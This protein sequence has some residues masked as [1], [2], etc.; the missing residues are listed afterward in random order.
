MWWLEHRRVRLRATSARTTQ[1]RTKRSAAA[2]RKTLQ[3]EVLEDRR[4]LASI[5]YDS[6]TQQVVMS[7]DDTDDYAY[8]LP[9]GDGQ[10]V[11]RIETTDDE[12]V[13][14]IYT[15][16]QV[17]EVVFMGKEGNDEF[18]NR[19]SIRSLAFGG[20]GDDGLN[21]GSGDDELDGGP[22]ADRLSGNLGNDVL[23]G[24]DGH[25]RI[26]GGDGDD[27]LQG[28][29]GDDRLY[30]DDGQDQLSGGD[31]EDRLYGDAG[32]DLI[33]GGDATD[34]MYGGGG[35]DVMYGNA[36]DDR[37]YGD[38]GNDQMYGDEGLDYLFGGAGDDELH[39][40]D[41]YDRLYGDTGNDRLSGD[42]GDDRLY[43]EAGDDEL[44]GG[45]GEDRLYG[46]DGQDLLDGGDAIDGMFGG[47]G[48]DQL[49]GGPGADRIYGEEG[50]DFIDAGPDDDKVFAGEGNDIIF[51][52]SGDDRVY[53]EG[54]HNHI[55]TGP[56]DDTAFG[57]DGDD[58]IETGDGDDKVFA[59]AG[60][61]VVKTGNGKDSVYGELGD[62]DIDT[63]EERDTAYGNEGNDV[64]HLGGDNDKAYG[65]SGNDILRGGAG[66]DDL[67]GESG[68]DMVIGNEGHDVLR[69]YDGRDLLVGGAGMDQLSADEQDDILIGGWTSY[70]GDDTAL[71]AIMDIWM[72][73]GDYDHRVGSLE[74]VGFA[75]YLRSGY[76]VHDDLVVDVLDGEENQDWYFLT[77]LLPGSGSYVL[78]NGVGHLHQMLGIDVPPDVDLLPAE[79]TVFDVLNNLDQYQ[80]EDGERL[81]TYL[82][83]STNPTMQL[84]HAALFA[85]VD[86]RDVTH[87]AISSGDWSDPLVW[88]QGEIPG[89]GARVQVPAGTVVTVDQQISADLRTV[90]VDGVLRFA[91][92]VDTELRV[93]TLVVSSA[94]HLEM[95]TE[96]HPIGSDVTARILITDTGP[97]DRVWDPLGLSRGVMIHGSAEI[98]GEPKTT[99][100]P[101]RVAPAAGASLLL[102]DGTPQNWR[103]G[104]TLVIAGTRFDHEDH[105]V[106]EI[107]A[108]FPEIGA[109]QV[110]PLEF[111]HLAPRPELQVH[112]AHTTR[113]AVVQSENPDLLR[114][115]HTMFMHT[116]R[117]QVHN[118][119]FYQL[120]RTD[121]LSEIDDARLDEDGRLIPGTGTNPRGRYSIH[122]HRGGIVDDGAPAVVQGVAVVDSPGWAVVVH[123]AFVEVSQSVVFNAAGASFVTEAGDEIGTFLDN[124]AIY[125]AGSGDG[126]T[127]R[128]SKQDFGHQGV[129]FWLQGSGMVVEG[130]IASGHAAHGFM[131]YS[132]GL[133]E[134]D[135][136]REPIFPAENL[137]D[138]AIAGGRA[139]VPVSDV[140]ILGFSDNISYDSIEGVNIRYHLEKADHEVRGLVDGL[141]LW[142]NET[143]MN[144]YYSRNLDIQDIMVVSRVRSFDGTG[145][146][147]NDASGDL[148]YRNVFV[149]GYFTGIDLPRGGNNEIVGGYFRNSNNIAVVS[150]ERERTILI[151]DVVFDPVEGFDAHTNVWMITR[152]GARDLWA[153]TPDRITLDY[154]PFSNA[155]LYFYEQAAD[156]VPF[157]Q[158]DDEIPDEFVGKSNAQLW[159]QFGLAVG[160]AVAT[161]DQAGSEYLID[162]IVDD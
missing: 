45:D 17:L 38:D 132:R 119:G 36:G 63:G 35:N 88:S 76:T 29:A 122:F 11:F 87:Q 155:R 5:T 48:D 138:P 15:E 52:G 14:R 125:T 108:V 79:Q 117:I 145:L 72:R 120:G 123:S 25:D 112:V 19:T 134:P 113:N 121:K 143:G 59:G 97:I 1:P 126:I 43:G 136:G 124:I 41:A 146:D 161:G 9:A 58:Y 51:A 107:L 78:Q 2:N 99:Q 159:D 150:A 139:G 62:D 152:F 101:L 31:G 115:G 65:G 33:F 153:L 22:G 105:E 95:G 18:D 3:F 61:D 68:D 118:A 129:G 21:G 111:D 12:D 40:G 71:R 103:V 144:V 83:H 86:V 141:L 80:L 90:R 127:D 47:S 92:Q 133:D 109:V 96:S 8:V 24:G 23:V 74:D 77:G 149:E 162:G 49:V 20:P 66:D 54:G 91:P 37:M 27:F 50:V 137:A 147:H 53:G 151:R 34:R 56:G 28:D 69:G 131:F 16:L 73:S 148:R 114:R 154:G 60:N 110:A 160:G 10:V 30:G 82:P 81:H 46:M 4:L 106:R 130:N 156:F 128:S 116:D 75:Y 158:F 57:N 44:Y 157:P 26:M 102:L 13:E 142:N 85:L 135:L 7:G 67:R 98:Y 100:L 89:A 70:D 93:D 140:P 42:E 64:I 55:E 104:D 94:G 84:N 39:G 6:L 32:A